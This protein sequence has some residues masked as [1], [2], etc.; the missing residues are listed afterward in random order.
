MRY[1][2]MDHT[3]GRRHTGPGAARS[4]KF[5]IRAIGHLPFSFWLVV[6]FAVFE[7]AGVQSFVCIST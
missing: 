4:G 3:S 7:N 5:D 1:D 6:M 2:V